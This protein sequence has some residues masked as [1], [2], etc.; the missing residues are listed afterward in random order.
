MYDTP[1]AILRSEVFATLA[2]MKYFPMQYTRSLH[3]SS[4]ISSRPF[5]HCTS[6]ASSVIIIALLTRPMIA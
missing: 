4:R 5:G 3:I 2:M 1:L 6:S